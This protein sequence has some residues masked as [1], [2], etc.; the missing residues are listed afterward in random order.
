MALKQTIAPQAGLQ[1]GLPAPMFVLAK[2]NNPRSKCK[3]PDASGR[4]FC[5]ST[6]AEESNKPLRIPCRRADFD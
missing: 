6:P 3:W 5:R 1:R 4:C 2:S